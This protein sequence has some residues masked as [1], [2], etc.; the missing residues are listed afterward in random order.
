MN[1][2][3]EQKAISLKYGTL[4]IECPLNLKVGISKNILNKELTMPINAMRY[5]PSKDT[6]VWYIWAGEEFSESNDFFVALHAEHLE[7]Y[8]PLIIKYLGLPPGWRVLIDDSAYEN[9]WYDSS[10]LVE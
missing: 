10:L 7:K 4:Y 2:V 3:E 9:V 6:T 1:K 5:L 8:C